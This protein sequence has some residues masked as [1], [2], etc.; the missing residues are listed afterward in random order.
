MPP[1]SPTRLV[2]PHLEDLTYVPRDWA[3]RAARLGAAARKVG[4]AYWLESVQAGG[5][6]ESL[7]LSDETVR[8]FG[9]DRFVIWWGRRALERAGLIRAHR[10]VGRPTLVTIRPVPPA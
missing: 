8:R 9:L 2:P 6:L 4:L 1:P 3:A 10:R 5:A 7:R